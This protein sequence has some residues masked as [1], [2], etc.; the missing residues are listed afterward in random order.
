[1]K[2][3]KLAGIVLVSGSLA[4]VVACRGDADGA[5]V[6]LP[7][8]P[9]IPDAPD[10]VDVAA[11]PDAAARPGDDRPDAGSPVA[12]RTCP[13][14]GKGAVSAP[15]GC[16]LITP[17]EAGASP[18][19]VNA[20]DDSYALEPGGTPRGT[21]L[22]V[23]P[24][25]GGVPSGIPTDPERNF[26]NAGATSGLHVLALAYRNDKPVGGLCQGQPDC[27]APTRESLILGKKVSGAHPSLD[28]IRTDEGIVARVEAALRALGAARLGK[29]WDA[30]LGAG[31]GTS[32]ERV[33]WP[34]VIVAGASQGGGHAAY[35]G[36]LV[37]VRRVIQFS[38]TCDATEAGPAPWTRAATGW[39]TSPA[40]SYWGYATATKFDGQGAPIG[41]D[42]TC[43]VHV[44]VWNSMGMA[45]SRMF[46]DASTCGVTG[47]THTVAIRCP[48]DYARWK[49]LLE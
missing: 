32:A 13:T 34:N 40:S 18:R 26:Y 21:L 35:L 49:T 9:P 43:P 2:L 41:G 5:P 44:A 24:G 4:A 15:Q 30:Y 19:G 29:G 33:T 3:T 25:T 39:A 27:F 8:S 46:D 6:A 31:G 37:T 45:P 38:A 36:K 14:S 11:P 20:M 48:D 10:A 7:S 23:L 17:A 42:T 1:M 28:D 16:F 47:N 12:L 22:V